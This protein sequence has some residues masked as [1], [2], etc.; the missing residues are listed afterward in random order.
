MVSKTNKAS[1][2]FGS[3]RRQ[4]FEAKFDKYLANKSQKLD[5]ALKAKE[6]EPEP[7]SMHRKSQ[8]VKKFT[9]VDQE[10]LIPQGFDEHLMR[11][12][13]LK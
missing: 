9:P 2:E 13:L 12:E 11:E 6:Q 3:P 8:S 7:F 5:F 10:Q 1:Q 4:I